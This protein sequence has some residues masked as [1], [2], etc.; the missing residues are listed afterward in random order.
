MALKVMLETSPNRICKINVVSASFMDLFTA[1][2]RHRSKS[3]RIKS[4]LQK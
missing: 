4:H 1:C 3:T 2:K